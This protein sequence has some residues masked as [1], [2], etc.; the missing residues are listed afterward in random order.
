M[1]YKKE[2]GHV[3]VDPL[4]VVVVLDFVNDDFRVG[5]AFY[6]KFLTCINSSS[7]F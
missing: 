5:Q 4:G 7:F 1:H 3:H 2:C 6:E